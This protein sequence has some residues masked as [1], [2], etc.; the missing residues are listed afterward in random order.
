MDSNTVPLQYSCLK[1]PL[2]RGAWWATVHGV[3]KSRTQLSDKHTHT[4]MAETNT[5][6]QSNY[7]P[8]KSK[9]FK[10]LHTLF[11]LYFSWTLHLGPLSWLKLKGNFR[12]QWPG[13]SSLSLSE[14]CRLR[15]CF[16]QNAEHS[17]V[18]C[19]HLQPQQA[20]IMLLTSQAEFYSVHVSW[21]PNY[22]GYRVGKFSFF[23][24]SNYIKERVST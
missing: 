18:A 2:D 7:L 10:I 24:L 17:K 4:H 1:N 23:P 15:H 5:T 12:D 14:N 16:L 19:V 9:V 22:N 20:M 13:C 21:H 11:K 8:I 3:A 6:L